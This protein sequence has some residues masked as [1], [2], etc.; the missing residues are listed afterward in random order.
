MVLRCSLLGHDFGEPEV[1]REREERGSEV[2]VTVQEF[3]ECV[4]CGERNVISE[5]TEVTS[6]P[7]GADV[8]SLPDDHEFKSTPEVTSEPDFEPA[9][10]TDVDTNDV[11]TEDIGADAAEAEDIGADAA[12]AEDVEI[13]DAEEP[14]TADDGDA[15]PETA[16]ADATTVDEARDDEHDVPDDGGEILDADSS[17]PT[18]NRDRSHGEWPESPDVDH[19]ADEAK[20]TEWPDTGDESADDTVVLEHDDA[21]YVT[22]S[23]DEIRVG[24]KDETTVTD[25]TPTDATVD[26]GRQ[27]S[28][29]FDSGSGIERDDSVPTPTENVVTA[30]DGPSEFYCPRCEYVVTN[31]RGS[32]RAGDICPDCR[33]GYL[34]ERSRR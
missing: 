24:T 28:A 14:E 22:D 16:T 6:L 15:E 5:N 2:V 4:R 23:P 13:I 17:S 9:E 32:L 12:E 31:D 3:E 18:Q 25:S 26:D 11:E 29:D 8:G 10:P 19:S 34:A 21:E 1:E 30:D 27:E 20:R 33:K 7:D